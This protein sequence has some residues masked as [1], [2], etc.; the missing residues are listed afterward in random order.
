MFHFPIHFQCGVR[1]TPRTLNGK[2]KNVHTF[3]TTK[4]AQMFCACLDIFLGKVTESHA[5]EMKGT[6]LKNKG[7]FQW[8]QI[9]PKE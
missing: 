1:L 8:G 2:N 6:L 3:R 9:D 7:K 4:S 5:P